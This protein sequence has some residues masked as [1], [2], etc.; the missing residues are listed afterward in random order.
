MSNQVLYPIEEAEQLVLKFLDGTLP[1]G[2]FT[3]EA[4][5]ISALYIL[6]RHGE[7]ALPLMRQH[8]AE[9]LLAAGVQQTATSGYHETMTVF[10]LEI[11]KNRFANAEGQVP[12]T[13]ETID[14]L[15][16]EETLADRNL[17]LAYYS[18]ERMMSAE[19]RRTYL[20]PDIKP[21]NQ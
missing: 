4:H 10:W 14:E 15:L 3:H 20:P 16:F 12:W 11:L 2:D 7:D 18:R 9:F 8:L 1:K 19:A 6:A 5:L 21:L 17:W 13:Q